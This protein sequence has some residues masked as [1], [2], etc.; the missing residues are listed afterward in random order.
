MVKTR[1]GLMSMFTTGSHVTLTSASSYNRA[2]T[3]VVLK[4]LLILSLYHFRVNNFGGI[5]K[6]AEDICRGTTSD[7]C[8]REV[9]VR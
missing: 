6:R 4:L 3:R 5:W 9:V 7:L 8:G 2:L 1:T